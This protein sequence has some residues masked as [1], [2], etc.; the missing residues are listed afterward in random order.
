MHPARPLCSLPAHAYTANEL[1]EDCL[2]AEDH[3]APT[4]ARP[5]RSPK[6]ARCVAYLEGFVNGYAV[7]DHLAEAV[8]VK[9]DAF[10]LPN[11]RDLSFRLV[12]AVLAHLD[13]Q[14]P[15]P[16]NQHGHAGR[17]GPLARLPV[18]RVA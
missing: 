12:R 2:A 18:Q 15:K 17:R 3:Y 1:R 16:R 10:C 7:S 5:L 4:A 8:G 14:P 9:L 6:A 11:R 13:R